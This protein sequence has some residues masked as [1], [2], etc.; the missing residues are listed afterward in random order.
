MVA[1]APV[2]SL[3]VM[4]TAILN[5]KRAKCFPNIVAGLRWPHKENTM[6]RKENG[7]ISGNK[8]K[9]MV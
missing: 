2:G 4:N 9:L 3:N 1:D 8:L 6:Q 5:S 7:A